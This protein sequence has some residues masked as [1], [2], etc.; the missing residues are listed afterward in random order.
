MSYAAIQ[1]SS[2]DDLRKIGNDPAYPLNG[3]YELTQDIDATG[4]NFTPIGTSTTPFVGKFDGKGYKIIGLNIYVGG[5]YI[6]LFSY[7]GTGGEVSNLGIENA[8]VYGVNIVGGLVGRNSGTVTGCYF[9]GS[10]TGNNNVG[11]L[12]GYNWG[13]S[14]SNSYAMGSV[15]GSGN[16]GRIGGL[17]GNLG[18]GTVTNTYSTCSVGGIGYNK[19]GLIGSGSGTITNS[20][21]DIETSGMTSSA[22]GEGKTTAEMKQAITFVGWDFTNV[23]GIMEDCSYP[24]LKVFSNPTTIVPNVL[25]L[26]RVNAESAIEDYCLVVSTVNEQCSD[27][28]P[29]GNVIN[30]SLVG[31]AQVPPGTAVDLVVSTGPCPVTVPNVVGMTQANAESAITGA[32]LTVGIV[33]LQCSDTVPAGKVITQTPLGGEQVLPGNAVDLVVS[34]GQCLSAI[35]S[36]VSSE[37]KKKQGDS[38]ELVVSIQGGSGTINYQWY[39][40]RES[41]GKAGG[42][43]IPGANGNILLLTNLTVGNTG[44]YWCEVSDDYDTVETPHIHLIVEEFGLSVISSYVML[45]LM[46]TMIFTGLY[47]MS[48]LNAVR[49]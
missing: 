22:G 10:V 31:G 13:G 9:R 18:G 45:V 43:P 30:Q 4:Q 1:I 17:I 47:R 21:W 42:E 16:P 41:E 8:S 34:R 15:S 7:I 5:N 3:E 46:V 23:W 20:Y 48:G 24:W 39:F 32:G 11:G 19:G 33:T 36:N 27:T 44:Y 40:E 37:I 25:G 35:I 14:V 38:L 28:V 12:I 6:G 26:S 29:A 2:I 49:E